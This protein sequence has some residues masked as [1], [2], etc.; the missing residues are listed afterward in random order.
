MGED[1]VDFIEDREEVGSEATDESVMGGIIPNNSNLNL[2]SDSN[3]LPS[4]P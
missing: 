4:A 1:L 3:R 2:Y